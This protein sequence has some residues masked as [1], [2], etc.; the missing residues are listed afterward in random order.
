MV[1]CVISKSVLWPTLKIAPGCPR[2]ARRN[3]RGC[4]PSVQR[5]ESHL[6]SSNNNIKA[7]M[8]TNRISSLFGQLSNYR[9]FFY[10]SRY[11]LFAIASWTPAIIFFNEHVGEVGII[12]GPSM[13]PYLNTGYNES[14]A[15]DLCWINKYD[16]TSNL[17]RGM[18]VAFRYISYLSTF[19]FNC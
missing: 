10:G 18:I 7:T 2:E 19:R 4:D 14:T 5:L 12:N 9:H 8:A 17:Q 15:K 1:K 11:A 3:S 16:P 6:N 13:S